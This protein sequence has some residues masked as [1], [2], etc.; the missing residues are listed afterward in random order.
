MTKQIRLAGDC[1]DNC[2]IHDSIVDGEGLRTTVFTQ[3]CL[4]NCYKCQNPQ[5]HPLDGGKV[6]DIEDI[7]KEISRPEQ[8]GITLSGGEPMLQAKACTELAK[9]VKEKLHQNVW[10]YTGFTYE[11]LMSTGTEEQKELLK[12]VDVLVDGAYIDSLRNLDLL[13]RGSSN[14]RIIRLEDGKIKSIDKDPDTDKFE[15]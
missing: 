3:G 11:D 13:F 7:E 9:Y 12:H 2:I 15:L 10:C 5:T 14:Q 4:R 1:Y 6:Y 8:S